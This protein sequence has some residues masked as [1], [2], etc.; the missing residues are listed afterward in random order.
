MEAKPRILIIYTGGTI[1]MIKNPVTDALETVDFNFIF[2]RV[3][4]LNRLQIE[5]DNKSVKKPV[6]SSDM[7]I[8][9]WR[10]IAKM[11]SENYTD[12]DGF[13]ILHGTDTMAYTASAL[14][15]MFEGLK[16]PVVL[17][18]AQLP[19]GIIRTDGKNNLI[20]A[21]E[22]VAEKRSN[23]E[24]MIQEV[25]VFFDD[26][27][28]RGNRS[29]KDS[30]TH[31]EAFRSPNFDELATAGVK[32]EYYENRFFT[33]ANIPFTT[34]REL[35]NRVALVKLFPGIKFE[36]YKDV[37]NKNHVDGVVIETFGAGNTPSSEYLKKLIVDF[38]SEG[39]V[40]LNITQCNSGT[41]KQGLYGSSTDFEEIGV[42]SGGNMTTEAAMTKMMVFLDVEDLE[43]S[44]GILA[45]EIRGE[46][47]Y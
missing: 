38:M 5:I 36:L 17:T 7:N 32:I 29:T 18:G 27:L 19:I 33:S 15:F 21:L 43:K 30:A 39:G 12:Y 28:F 13:L 45:R 35:N 4:E 44:K 34:H 31:F 25:A 9:H 2:D 40:V 10:E 20:S 16:K 42:I 26:R 14:S 3:P 41:V 6:D 8:S 1:G 37:F 24:P 11:V 47:D 46:V 23:G 22:V